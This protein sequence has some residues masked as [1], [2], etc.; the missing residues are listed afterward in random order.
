MQA[1]GVPCP[2]CPWI[3]VSDLSATELPVADGR[4]VRLRLH[5]ADVIFTRQEFYIA[6]K[7]AKAV[8]RVEQLQRRQPE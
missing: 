1:D 8:R 7:R 4:F 2:I 3:I 5:K 6:L